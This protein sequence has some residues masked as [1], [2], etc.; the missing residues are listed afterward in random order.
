V[1]GA[2]VGGYYGPKDLMEFYL[3]TQCSVLAAIITEVVEDC[4][5]AASGANIG[6]NAEVSRCQVVSAI[7]DRFGTTVN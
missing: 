5:D 2:G 4:I 3:S 7:R 6:S 1:P